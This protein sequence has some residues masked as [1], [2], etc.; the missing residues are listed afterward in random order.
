[1][2]LTSVVQAERLN[3]SL[4]GRR[5][6]NDVNLEV[7]ASDF[8][9]LLGGNGSGKTTLVRAL[10][11][12]V[13]HDS[14]RVHLLGMSL[15]RFSEWHRVGYV[16]QRLA[17]PSSVPATVAEV[18]QSGRIAHAGF[19][20]PYSK[21]DRAAAESALDQADLTELQHE[22]VSRLSGGQQQRV[23]IARALASEPDVIVLDEPVSHVD[24]AHQ[25]QFAHL[26]H[27][28]HEGGATVLL[29]AHELGKMAGLATRAVVLDAGSIVYDGAPE[30]TS[31]H[32]HDIHH[33][34]TDDRSTLRPI[35]GDR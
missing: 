30:G 2:Q 16:P 4:A 34:D 28:A 7:Q 29:V 3:V 6:L 25:T 31:L 8:V 13:P 26:V 14:G 32:D 15:Q 12:L 22:R 19:W 21:K 35:G 17:L 18:V 1:M 23:L 20:R 10:L 11:G 27:A 24:V 9:V 5:V 33:H